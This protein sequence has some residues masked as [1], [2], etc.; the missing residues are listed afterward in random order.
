MS[1][2]GRSEADPPRSTSARVVMIVEDDDDIRESLAELLKTWRVATVAVNSA[3][4]ALGMLRRGFEPCLILL[5]L[6]M[7][8]LSGWDFRR[9]QMKDP[10]LNR[11]PVVI[12][13]ALGSADEAASAGLGDVTWLPK[14]F[15]PDRLKEVLFA[16]VELPG[17]APGRTDGDRRAKSG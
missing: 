5:D 13:T 16:A 4:V 15:S 2:E 3:E 8:G 11:I 10:R 12:S 1:R 7:L 6:K 17:G 14:P 9:E